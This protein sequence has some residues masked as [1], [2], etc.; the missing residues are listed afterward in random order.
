MDTHSSRRVIL[1]FGLGSYGAVVR[2]GTDEALLS[3]IAIAPHALVF[4]SVPWS[5][6]ERTARADFDKAVARLMGFGL[7]V[8]AFTLDEESELAQRWLSSLGLPEPYG[9]GVPIGW[10]SVIWLETGRVVGFVGHGIDER[11]VGIIGRTKKLWGQQR[12]TS[13]SS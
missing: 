4:L 10:G 7:S 1:A 11:A 6:P 12:R 13:S 3:A 2:E 9:Q 5:C 8:E